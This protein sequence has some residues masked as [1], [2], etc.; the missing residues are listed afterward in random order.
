M[1]STGLFGRIFSAVAVSPVRLDRTDAMLGQRPGHRV[2]QPGARRHLGERFLRHLRY[3]V[4]IDQ[5]LLETERLRDRPCE[6]IRAPA[7]RST[8]PVPSSA[9]SSRVL[10]RR[11]LRSTSKLYG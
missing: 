9:L 7:P 6:D 4:E 1:V 8:S 3:R 11:A 5:A 2:Q 10:R